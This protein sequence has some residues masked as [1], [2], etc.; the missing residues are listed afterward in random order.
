MAKMVEVTD[1]DISIYISKLPS[2][3]LQ[4][5]NVYGFDFHKFAIIQI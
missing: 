2:G 1:F 3:N 4:Q 5:I